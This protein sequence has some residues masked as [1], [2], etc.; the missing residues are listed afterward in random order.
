[1]ARGEAFPSSCMGRTAKLKQTPNQLYVI[2]KCSKAKW[3][4][5]L[6]FCKPHTAWDSQ[7]SLFWS[8]PLLTFAPPSQKARAALFSLRQYANSRVQ[9]LPVTHLVQYPVVPVRVLIRVRPGYTLGSSRSVA[10]ACCFWER[11][12]HETHT[13]ISVSYLGNLVKTDA[14]DCTL[15]G[16]V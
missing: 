1:M 8:W 12:I 15:E 5:R 4:A 2:F 16:R 7:V 11:Q 10:T 3:W 13:W 14:S 6:N 9:K